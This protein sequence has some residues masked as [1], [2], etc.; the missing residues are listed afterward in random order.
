MFGSP[1]DQRP[2][3]TSTASYV[4]A[5]AQGNALSQLQPAQVRQMRE[6]FQILDRDSDG[7]VNREDVADMLTQLGALHRDYKNGLYEC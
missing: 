4:S 1:R 2:S 6:G 7:S 5:V 3:I